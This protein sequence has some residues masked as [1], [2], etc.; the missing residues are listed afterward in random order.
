MPFG[1]KTIMDLREEFV[2]L[3]LAPGANR[4]QLCRRFNVS[5]PT[6]YK[7]IDRYVKAGQGGLADHSRR[8]QASPRK[9]SLQEEEKVIELRKTHPEW[10]ARKLRRLL[11]E[12]GGAP[13]SA[14][15]ITAI[16][17]R[18]G[19]AHPAPERLGDPLRFERERPNELWQMDFK[20]PVALGH[21][22]CQ[23]LDVLDDHSRFCLGLD[24]CPDQR[25]ATVKAFLQGLFER[26]GLPEA[27]LMD[28][29]SPWRA[30][31][32]QP[33]SALTVWLMRLGVAVSHGRPY[34]PQTQGKIER[35]HRTLSREVLRH[36]IASDREACQRILDAWRLVYN[37]QRPH[38]ALG[39]ATPAT[40]WQP[41]A[42]SMPAR[43]PEID[44]APGD[45]VRMVAREGRIVFESR[46]FFVGCP[47]AGLPVALRPTARD[48]FVDVFFCH[49]KIAEINLHEE[50]GA[51]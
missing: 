17:K 23:I 18:A 41:S 22:Q 15:T 1:P 35:F 34:H 11:M 26:F 20:G 27:M 51:A 33:Y 16:L 4:R 46:R 21:G 28:N 43:L 2:L 48:G 36:M 24:A 40:R 3:A 42:R 49:Q 29:G 37:F 10:G 50:A 38:D 14:S 32:D 47:F 8:P 45:V 7:W 44:Y 5:P 6:A 9:S 12:S 39:L 31:P 13:P 30:S 25:G 19:L